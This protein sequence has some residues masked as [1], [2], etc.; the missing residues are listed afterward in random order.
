MEGKGIGGWEGE[1]SLVPILQK[2]YKKLRMESGELEPSQVSLV[3]YEELMRKKFW[4]LR[5][6]WEA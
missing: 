5:N 6:D 1:D 4:S 3:V 2:K